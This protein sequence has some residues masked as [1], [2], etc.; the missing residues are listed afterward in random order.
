M[1]SPRDVSPPARRR[2]SLHDR[3]YAPVETDVAGECRRLLGCN[4]AVAMLCVLFTICCLVVT[5]I[6][7]PVSSKVGSA[8]RLHP[9]PHLAPSP[10]TESWDPSDAWHSP[11][12]APTAAPTAHRTSPWPEWP[13]WPTTARSTPRPTRAPPMVLITGPPDAMEWKPRDEVAP[14][15]S[16]EGRL[17]IPQ[18]AD[19]GDVV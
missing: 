9:A 15:P 16:D 6:M 17:F 14:S 4:L 7:D 18:P 3:D 10:A 12:P 8:S 19:A 1:A 13:Q 5:V 11:A 2:N